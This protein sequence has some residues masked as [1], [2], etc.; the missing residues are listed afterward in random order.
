MLGSKYECKKHN[1][2]IYVGDKVINLKNNY[3][4]FSPTGEK[5]P[6]A[7]GNMGIV[8]QVT[9]NSIIIDFQM[10]GEVEIE[11]EARENINLAYAITIHSSQGSQFKHTIV[12]IDGASYIMGNV[13][14]LYTGITRAQK[15][16]YLV[17]EPSIITKCLKTVENHQKQTYLCRILN[18]FE[19]PSI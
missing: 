16:C 11:G 17:A 10:Q 3:E 9:E 6:I 14:I 15:H 18:S 5:R 7:N 19:R 4:T 1:C 12:A 13:E 2:N 8:R